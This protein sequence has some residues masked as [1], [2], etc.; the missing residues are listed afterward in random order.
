VSAL[1][2]FL[3]PFEK[4][5]RLVQSFSQVESEDVFGTDETSSSLVT[6]EAVDAPI[7]GDAN[8]AAVSS[9]GA[10][11]DFVFGARDSLGLEV[12]SVRD[13]LPSASSAQLITAAAD[14]LTDWESLAGV[15]APEDEALLAD[16]PGAAT[17]P[18]AA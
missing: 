5:S 9:L 6:V 10:A 11:T 4:I 13:S 15:T 8:A 16:E 17:R 12:F 14:V 7:S 18:L 2:F 1:A 3:F